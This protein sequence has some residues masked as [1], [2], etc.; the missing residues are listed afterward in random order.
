MPE[1]TDPYLRPAPPEGAP[2]LR[3]P[4]GWAAEPAGVW[5]DRQMEV[6]YNPRRH[7]VVFI[8]GRLAPDVGS[9]LP[10]VG[11]AEARAAEGVRMF[12]RDRS[13]ATRAALDR[14]EQRPPVARELGRTH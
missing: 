12:V 1:P 11:Y 14:L 6:V 4:E 8:R 7:D 5:E 2:P 9:A 13:A 3:C 10:S